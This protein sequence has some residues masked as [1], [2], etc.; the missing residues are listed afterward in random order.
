MTKEGKERCEFAVKAGAWR[1]GRL[2]SMAT[3]QKFPVQTHF[4]IVAANIHTD[5][6]FKS[7]T[8]N[9]SQPQFG[10]LVLWEISDWLLCTAWKDIRR[11][12]DSFGSLL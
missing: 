1:P 6:T 9:T 10:A 4:Q 3:W 8:K 7:R 12:G 11:D 5:E 2:V